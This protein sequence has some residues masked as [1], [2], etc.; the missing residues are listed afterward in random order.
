MPV[1]FGDTGIVPRSDVIAAQVICQTEHFAPLDGTIAQHARVGRTPCH[2]LVNE[3]AD[4]T[5][6]E[7][8][9]VTCQQQGVVL[10]LI[11]TVQRADMCLSVEYQVTIEIQGAQWTGKLD[12]AHGITFNLVDEGLRERLGKLQSGALGSEVEVEIVTLRRYI[13]TNHG[14]GPG[15][16][17][18]CLNVNLFLFGIPFDQRPC[19]NSNPLT[20]ILA[21]ASKSPKTPLTTPLPVIFPLKLTASKLTKS[22]M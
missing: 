10:H 13:A 7:G 18:Q 15:V 12:V 20:S 5:V 16:Y 1:P 22:R 14:S 11:G 9:V 8:D 2:I 6:L 19:S 4:D 21:S 17:G 3:V